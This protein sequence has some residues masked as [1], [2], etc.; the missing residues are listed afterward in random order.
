MEPLHWVRRNTIDFSKLS[1]P[2]LLSEEAPG[3]HVNATA[4]ASR[5]VASKRAKLLMNVTFMAVPLAREF[6][7][8]GRRQ[9]D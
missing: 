5:N 3:A 8:F 4:A 6:G 9:P 1:K 7:E 2:A